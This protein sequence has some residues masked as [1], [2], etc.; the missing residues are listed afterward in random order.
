MNTFIEVEYFCSTCNINFCVHH[1][2]EFR[3]THC[4]YCNSEIKE[5][6]L[7]SKI[8]GE[9]YVTYRNGKEI[10]RR[11]I[12]KTTKIHPDHLDVKL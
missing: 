1:Y 11:E 10:A 5:T 12:K 6:G 7:T 8:D 3:N 9:E 4:C 2:S